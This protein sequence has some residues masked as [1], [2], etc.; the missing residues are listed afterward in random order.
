MSRIAVCRSS[1][2]SSLTPMPTQPGI[3]PTGDRMCWYV[4]SHSKPGKR[5]IVDATANMGAMFCHCPDFRARMQP[6]I[7]AGL[8]VLTPRHRAAKRPDGETAATICQHCEDLILYFCRETFRAM[9]ESE[10]TPPEK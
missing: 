7:D 10:M 4:P 2:G 1:A 8:P 5:Y 6:N 9:A 3:T